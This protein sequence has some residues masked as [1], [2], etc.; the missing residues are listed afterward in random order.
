MNHPYPCPCC[1]HVVFDE[2]PGSYDICPVCFWEDD[3]VQ[4]R[5]PDWAGGANKPSLIDG[6]A[7]YQH[8]GVC[9]QRLLAH[10]RAPAPDEPREPGW[11]RVDLA[12]DN[13]EPRTVQ[14]APWPDDRTVLYWW[15]KTFWRRAGDRSGGDTG[16]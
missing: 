14:E 10:V 6:Q 2:P 12:A 3:I 11:R 16:R 8:L 9:E 4:L 15:R 7:N 1:G 13:F 5:W